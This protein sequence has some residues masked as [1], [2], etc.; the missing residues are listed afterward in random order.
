[1]SFNE[2]EIGMTHAANIGSRP[3]GDLQVRKFIGW[4]LATRSNA[5]FRAVKDILVSSG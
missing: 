4:S 5:L 1:M 3:F 2:T